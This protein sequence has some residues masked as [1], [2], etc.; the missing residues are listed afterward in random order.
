[1]AVLRTHKVEI[2]IF[3]L[4]GTFL[5]ELTQPSPLPIPKPHRPKPPPPLK[6][7]SI[8]N[9]LV[10]ILSGRNAIDM[11]YSPHPAIQS[12]DTHRL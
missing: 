3:L 11:N 2:L 4:W 6:S 12:C 7:P 9:T 5:A 8:S 10:E 1:M